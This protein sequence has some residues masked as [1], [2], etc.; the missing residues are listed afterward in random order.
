MHSLTSDENPFGTPS[1]VYISKKP[2]IAFGSTDVDFE[3]FDCDVHDFDA[4]IESVVQDSIDNARFVANDTSHT[5]T[6]EINITPK[7][8]RE[9][10]KM[11]RMPKLPRKIKKYAKVNYFDKYPKRIERA[12]LNLAFAI[13]NPQKA[14]KVGIR[15]DLQK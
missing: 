7:Q 4:A 2:I 1:K 15:I 11:L 6:M 5:I 12:M 13:N 14:K 10:K 9:L 8:M 3:E